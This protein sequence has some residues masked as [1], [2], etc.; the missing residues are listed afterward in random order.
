[1]RLLSSLGARARRRNRS[2]PGL[3]RDDAAT[4][5]AYLNMENTAITSEGA[6]RSM[7]RHAGDPRPDGESPPVTE[8]RPAK[9]R[10][11]MRE[12]WQRRDVAR[13]V[14]VRDIKI[15]YKQSILGPL[16]LVLQPL[17]VLIGLIFVFN[18]VTTVNTG[19]IPYVVFA[20]AS[21]SAWTF[22]QLSF[23]TGTN[24]FLLNSALIRRV[25]F[26]R[27]ALFTAALLSNLVPAAVI[28]VLAIIGTVISEGI[29]WQIVLL[30]LVAVWFM[31]LMAGVMFA[32]ASLTVRY[33][34]VMALV[35]F[36]LQVGVFLTPVGYPLMSAPQTLKT[37]LSLNPLTGLME[38]WRWCMFDSAVSTLPI[39]TA[40]VG[41]VVTVAAGWW[42]FSRLEG[43]FA[44][45]I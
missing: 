18:G 28:F 45:F 1:M 39:I 31:A 36:W 13:I 6:V 25:A 26:P 19:G 15:R 22:V 16:W 11:K 43:R 12:L 35:P 41:T 32:T 30:P 7:L 3:L 10:V 24:V 17:G 5:P 4:L 21:M 9:S 29:H 44:D 8:I 27:T 38:L 20:L 23:S 42:I 34:D 37:L 14:A 33:R 40:I 2:T